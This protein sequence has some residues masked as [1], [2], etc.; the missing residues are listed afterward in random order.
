MTIFKTFLRLVRRDWIMILIYLGIFAGMGPAVASSNA[1]VQ[2]NAF[3]DS[4]ISVYVLD[5]DQ[6]SLSA[7]VSAFLDENETIVDLGTSDLRKINDSIRFGLADAAVIIPEGYEK[8]FLRKA[9]SATSRAGETEAAVTQETK[10]AAVPE[11]KGAADSSVE[12][13]ENSTAEGTSNSL[14]RYISSGNSAG[15]V[16]LSQKIE[17]FLRDVKAYR[18]LGSSIEEAAQKALE[19]T[20]KAES[21]EV[22]LLASDK[23]EG[24]GYLYYL[25]NFAG[26]GL[27]M[28]LCEVIGIVY[29]HFRNEETMRRID[30]S[31]YGF[32]RKNREIILGIFVSA[33]ILFLPFA[34]LPLLFA[35]GQPDQSKFL[36]YTLS[37]LILLVPGVGLGFLINALSKNDSQVNILANSIVLTMCFLSGLFIP[38]ELLSPG[39]LKVARVLPLYWYVEAN[40]YVNAVVPGAA[41]SAAAAGTAALN[42]GGAGAGTAA[43]SGGGAYTGTAPLIGVSALPA[44]FWRCAAVEIFFGIVLLAVGLLLQRSASRRGVGR[45]KTKKKKQEN[46]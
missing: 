44:A 7:Q 14:I 32:A 39:T 16:L 30:V 4:K 24:H 35:G 31:S 5:N 46:N 22:T 28:V 41:G 19:V 25:F 45:Q 8:E 34:L 23:T 18:Q 36:L 17:T 10:T 40:E 9:A 15:S 43:L 42:A 6:S 13:A 12:G 1:T 11:A 26:Y 2:E 27:L 38:R 29:G 21:A 3:S 37:L 20:G 33:L